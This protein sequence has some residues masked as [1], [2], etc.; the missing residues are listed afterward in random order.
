MLRDMVSN[1]GIVYYVG[2]IQ[3]SIPVKPS[4][5]TFNELIHCLERLEPSTV[6]IIIVGNY[7][8]GEPV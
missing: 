5:D 2:V 3:N 4:Y 7:F 8:F 6:E 1:V